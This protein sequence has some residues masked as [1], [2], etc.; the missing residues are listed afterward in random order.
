MLRP[1]CR[2]ACGQADGPCGLDLGLHNHEAAPHIG[3]VKDRGGMD[4][5]PGGAA[6]FAV[7]RIGQGR[8]I[9]ALGNANALHA[10][11]EAGGIHHGEHVGQAIA[12]LT[13]QLGPSA[14]KQ[15]GTGR[16]AMNAQLMLYAAWP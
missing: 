15:H 3:M 12:D 7:N 11:I 6:L 9:G 16:R 2:Y 5:G 4:T 1:V 14:I 13:N 10:D 8:L